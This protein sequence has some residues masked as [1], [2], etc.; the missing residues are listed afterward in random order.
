MVVALGTSDHHAAGAKNQDHDRARLGAVH[1]P[2]KDRALKGAERRHGRV[3]FFNVD[4]LEVR[5]LDVADNVLNKKVLLAKG[6]KGKDFS[7]H[8]HD[9]ARGVQAHLLRGRAGDD[10]LTVRGI[11]LWLAQDRRTRRVNLTLNLVVTGI[12]C[13]N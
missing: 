9:P 11:F 2:R 6:L 8:D 3:H 10:H 5:D 4:P 12:E 13:H 1:E 7:Q